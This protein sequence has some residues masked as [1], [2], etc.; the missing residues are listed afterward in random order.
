MTGERDEDGFVLDE[1]GQPWGHCNA[2]GE[3][4]PAYSEHC[5]DGEVVPEEVVPDDQ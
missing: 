2:C 1:Y 3:E 4:A 5:D